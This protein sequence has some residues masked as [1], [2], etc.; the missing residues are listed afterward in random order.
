LFSVGE[1]WSIFSTLE[2]GL[3]LTEG[4]LTLVVPI[5]WVLF[6]PACTFAAVLGPPPVRSL[7]AGLL[8]LLVDM[9]TRSSS[10]IRDEGP[11]NNLDHLHLAL[12][13]CITEYS[14]E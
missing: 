9:K 8:Q 12:K 10:N 14:C 7:R 1:D 11:D 5:V 13:N 4:A 3:T 2:L 6:L